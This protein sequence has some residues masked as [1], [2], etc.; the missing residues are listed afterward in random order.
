MTRTIILALIVAAG[1]T[2]AP[3]LAAKDDDHSHAEHHGEEVHAEGDHNHGDEHN[4]NDEHDH[5]D[6]HDHGEEHGSEAADADSDHLSIGNGYRVLHA[7]TRATSASET[8]IFME[9][10]NTSGD[11][12]MLEGALARDGRVLTL[13]GLSADGTTETLPFVPIPAGR[14]LV[15]EPFGLTLRLS[16]LK[17]PLA[18]GDE[19]E[20]EV[21]MSAGNVVV[22]VE[23]EAADARQHSHA[24]H[25]H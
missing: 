21:E 10:D 14:E 2:A 8:D 25:A 16:D 22:H 24:G 18:K 12:M 11:E 19:F 3:A 4:H 6:E 17:G 9:I 23:V 20:I 1:L 5:D 13:V 15:L 7:W